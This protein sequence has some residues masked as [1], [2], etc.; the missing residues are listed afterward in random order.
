MENMFVEE[1]INNGPI[2]VQGD[3]PAANFDNFIQL[4]EGVQNIMLAYFDVDAKNLEPQNNPPPPPVD[5][6]IPVN[7]ED[8]MFD[9]NNLV[10]PEV[11]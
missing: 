8:V 7:N 1:E 6:A 3:L 11:A 10:P 4:G 5:D 2:I 9:D